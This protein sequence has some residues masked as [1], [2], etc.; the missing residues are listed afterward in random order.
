MLKWVHHFQQFRGHNL[1]KQNK[2]L[3]AIMRNFPPTWQCPGWKVEEL[4]WVA[5]VTVLQTREVQKVLCF[6]GHLGFYLLL[7]SPL[8]TPSI[9]FINV[10][11]CINLYTLLDPD[12]MLLPCLSGIVF[13]FSQFQR[14]LGLGAVAPWWATREREQDARKLEEG[15]DKWGLIKMHVC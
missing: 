3:Q 14:F 5:Q 4:H 6:H 9:E 10:A 8:R 1:K 7:A 2:K 13:F 11:A 12:K 15:Q